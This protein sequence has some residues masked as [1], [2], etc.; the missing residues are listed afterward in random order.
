MQN[1]NKALA[2]IFDMDGVII[3]SNPLITVAWKAFFETH[4]IELSDEQLNHY[5]FGRTAPETVV[6]V[7]PEGLTPELING[8]AD[9]VAT[10]VQRMYISNG[11]IVPGFTALV[12]HLASHQ[13][14][15]AIATSAPTEN[16]KI[17]LELAGVGDYIIG[18]LWAA[19]L[20]IQ[21]SNHFLFDLG[22]LANLKL[23]KSIG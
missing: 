16:V 5:V 8:Y 22:R 11:Q 13:I 12:K 23:W 4:H 1:T 17:V 6:M 20:T 10:E 19:D 9:E 7:F 15:M 2:A 18:I 3:D 21:F 14:P